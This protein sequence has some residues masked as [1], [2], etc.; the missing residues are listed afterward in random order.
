MS[1]AASQSKLDAQQS[2]LEAQVV[3]LEREAALYKKARTK[4]EAMD[5]FG[6]YIKEHER[7]EPF[8]TAYE[9]RPNPY[10][11]NPGHNTSC[12]RIS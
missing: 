6:K 4:Q 8:S 3:R 5:S 1:D 10:Y 9:G 7:E 2:K 12:C 11:A